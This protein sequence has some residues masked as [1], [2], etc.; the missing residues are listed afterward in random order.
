MKSFAVLLVIIGLF[1][2]IYSQDKNAI[3]KD[4]KAKYAQTQKDIKNIKPRVY[5]IDD[6]G[7]TTTY[8]CYLKDKN[9]VMVE[10]CFVGGGDCGN[11]IKYYLDNNQPYFV[12]DNT[13]CYVGEKT[14]KTEIRFYVS[15]KQVIKWLEG[16]KD[17]KV[18]D[19]NEK[20]K[21]L[22]GT[23]DEIIKILPKAK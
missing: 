3:I 9:I 13:E 4:I 22:M 5:T 10:K 7:E 18:E 19:F 20:Y 12:F 2:T 6:N 17:I 14:S 8:S 23:L 16:K 11:C 1:G 15:N 21:E